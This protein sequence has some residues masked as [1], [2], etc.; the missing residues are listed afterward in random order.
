MNWDVEIAKGLSC[1]GSE[2]VYATQRK[3]VGKWNVGVFLN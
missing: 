2:E 3:E 1:S